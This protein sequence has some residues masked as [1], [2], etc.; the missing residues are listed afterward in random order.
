MDG[1]VKKWQWLVAFVLCFT[2]W[3]TKQMPTT[4]VTAKI[5][6]VIYSQDD[7]LYM[8]STLQAFPIFQREKVEVATYP[9]EQ[10]MLQ[11]TAILPTHKGFLLTFDEQLPLYA[12]QNGIVVY[13]AY[14]K[15]TGQTITVHYEDQTTVTYGYLDQLAILPYTAIQKNEQFGMK[16]S[17]DLYIRIEKEGQILNLEQTLSWL[18]EQM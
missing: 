9:S 4:N 17:G 8:R 11:Y 2:I 1:G 6:R 10:H 13:T 16:E 18:K 14:T 3:A 7:L 12:L 5:Q 15:E